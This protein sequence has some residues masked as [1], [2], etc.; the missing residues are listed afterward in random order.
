[1]LNA[2][3]IHHLSQNDSEVARDILHN[4]YVDNLV[5]GCHT[6]QG[7]LKYFLESRTLLNN[8]NFNLRSWISNSRLLM[9]A[10][11][12]NNVME[13]SNPVKV[14]GLVWDAQLDLIFPSPKPESVN[15][16]SARTKR[17]ILKC[18]SSI[19]DPLGLI[20]PVTIS[21]KLFI[22]QLWQ[23]RH[24]WDSDLDEH[25]VQLGIPLLVIY[26]MLQCCHTLEGALPHYTLLMQFYM[27][28]QMPA[29]GHMVEPH[30]F[31]LEQL[32]IL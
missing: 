10:A 16:T 21:A 1:M 28:L 29:Q 23:Q 8:V 32:R 12:E 18:A 27:F 5:S 31:N 13:T 25:S 2:A 6:E 3:I 15:F 9:S 19:F 14:L 30:T 24:K 17:A 7:A 11:K 26:S 20:T 22:Q 4:L